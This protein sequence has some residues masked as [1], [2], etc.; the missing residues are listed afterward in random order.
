MELF[1][2]FAVCILSYLLGSVTFATIVSKVIAGKDIRTLGN[3]NAGMS[4][5]IMSVGAKPGIITFLGDFGKGVLSVLLA[6]MIFGF[7]ETKIG[8]LAALCAMLGHLYPVFFGF[9]GGKG[10]AVMGGAI[11]AIRPLLFLVIIAV[12]LI[13]LFT[14]KYIALST[15]ACSIIYPV[16]MGFDSENTY[17]GYIIVLCICVTILSVSKHIENIYKIKNGEEIK[18]SPEMFKKGKVEKT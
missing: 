4:N 15:I 10:T 14:T 3:H 13:I 16:W 11:L 2:L 18:F 9:R 7:G 5:M 1:K 6:F 12:F 17:K 8:V